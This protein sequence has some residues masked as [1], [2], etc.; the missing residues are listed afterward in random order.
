MVRTSVAQKER[1]EWARFRDV[2]LRRSAAQSNLG[3]HLKCAGRK[4]GRYVKWPESAFSAEDSPIVVGVLGQ[5]PLG[6]ALE[7]VLADSS[8]RGRGYELRSLGGLADAEGCHM[9]IVTERDR[10]ELQYGG[11][12]K[13]RGSE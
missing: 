1:D 4:A 3:R 11:N 7:G 9:L 8:V 10:G 2:G 5:A 12:I 6:T 13:Q